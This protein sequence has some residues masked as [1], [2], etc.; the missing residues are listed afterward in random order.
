MADSKKI[1]S[2]LKEVLK[3]VK[4]SDEEMNEINGKLK[5]FLKKID[6]SRKKERI[7]AEIFVGGSSAKGTMIKKDSYDI[8]IFIRFDKKYKDTLL[9][10]ITQKILKGERF[11]RIHGSRDYFKIRAGKNVFFEIVPVKKVKNPKESENVTDLSYS[12]VSYIKKRI[13]TQK[14]LDE[15]RVAKAFCYANDVYGAESYVHGFSGYGIELL[16]YHYKSF[17][18]FIKGMTKIKDKEVIDIEKL[19]KNKGSIMLDLNSAKL[20]SPIIL[21]D[22]T[23]KQRN[24]LAALSY[25][26]FRRFQEV[27]REFLKKPEIKFF[28]QEEINLEKLKKDA[29]KKGYEFSLVS[30]ETDRQEG[31]IAGS[32]MQKFY[33]HLCSEI[34]LSFDIK[35]KGFEYE[36]RKD[37]RA[38]FVGKRKKD[39]ILIGPKVSDEKNAKK[40]RQKHKIVT[41][42]NGRL[43][44]KAQINGSLN[45]FLKVWIV[46]N[47]K[48][49][50]DM[51]I[52]MMNVIG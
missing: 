19:H 8:D 50:E 25:E 1:S 4:P 52:T 9:S 16:I 10:D 32:K 45:D 12:H 35:E 43:Y 51:G 39:L 18:N 40:F 3:H 26:T 20:K 30:I 24:V 17:M 7:N 33:R 31:D 2:I 44:A 42:K 47:I 28:Q 23:Y 21:I 22:P 14:T 5:I 49:I 13:K 41:I 36:K 11:E 15:I 34:E 6:S 48:I 29:I 37:A 46:K 38:F 27:C